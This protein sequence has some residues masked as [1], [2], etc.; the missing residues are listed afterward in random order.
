MLAGVE[1]P[2]AGKIVWGHQA[3]VGYLP[4]D[5][6]GT[7]AKGTT[8]FGW[9]RDLNHKLSNEE[10]SGLLG[11]MLFSGEERMKPTDTLS[12]G[13]TVRLLL[14][15]LMMTKDNVLVLDEPTNHLDLESISALAD[16]H[17]EVRGHGDRGHPRPGADPRGRDPHLGAPRGPGDH[18]LQRRLR[19]LRP[20]ARR[21]RPAP[22][23]EALAKVALQCIAGDARD[24]RPYREALGGARADLLLTDPPYC[25][26]TRRRK[27]G[28]LRESKG[29]KLD[30]E[31]VIRFDDVR[32]YRQF[33][34]GWLPKAVAHLTPDAKLVIWTNFLG[35]EPILQVAR[36]LG[37][38]H[39]WGE[40]VWAKR[41]KEGGGNEQLLRVYEIALV[42]ARTPAPPEDPAALPV[43][44]SAVTGYDDEG[45]GQ[46][47]GS[48]PHHK[49]FSALDALVRTY[50][51]PGQRVLDPFAGSGSIPVA[52][53]RLGR[54]VSCIELVPEWAA[55]IT[56]R[57][58][59]GR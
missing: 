49:P 29:R 15:K 20:E 42:L 18:R 37:Y 13:E 38:G 30:H 47:W 27:G 23:L 24:E 57:L 22:A 35:K 10:I 44:W 55:R 33:T 48:H 54:E 1:E 19:G 40:F 56:E 59:A 43:P 32:A 11:R 7:I 6:H 28:D 3:S 5:H 14:S 46:T 52:A 51:R 16:G 2:D 9:L 36:D 12:G 4:Q 50:S 8:A 25:L 26:L 41:T 31:I 45:E 17:P 53:H 58:N 34:E 21:R 39:L